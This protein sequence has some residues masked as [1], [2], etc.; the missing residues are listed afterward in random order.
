VSEVGVGADTMRLWGAVNI[1]H[2]ALVFFTSH[3]NDRFVT[4]AP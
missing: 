2:D 4:S 3:E 1:A